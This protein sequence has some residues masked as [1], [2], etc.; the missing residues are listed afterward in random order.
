MEGAAFKIPLTLGEV[1]LITPLTQQTFNEQQLCASHC[2]RP[3][4]IMINVTGS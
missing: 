3:R 4:L 2:W 1:V